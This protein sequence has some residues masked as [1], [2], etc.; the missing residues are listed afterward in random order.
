MAEI[1]QK[2]VK[3]ARKRANLGFF[4][5]FEA[6]KIFQKKFNT[7]LESERRARH[8][9]LLFVAFL[10]RGVS[11]Y[12]AEGCKMLQVELFHKIYPLIFAGTATTKTGLA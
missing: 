2:W 7:S 3:L 11:T 4:N 9:E 5:Y 12:E 10:R 6:R 1:G 8:F